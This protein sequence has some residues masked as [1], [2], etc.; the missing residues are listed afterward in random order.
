[1]ARDGEVLH[2]DPARVWGYRKHVDVATGQLG[3]V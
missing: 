2:G 1:M 3:W